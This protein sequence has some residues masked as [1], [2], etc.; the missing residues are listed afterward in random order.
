MDPQ[1]ADS[2]ADGLHVAEQAI[3]KV[4]QPGCDHASSAFVFEPGPPGP[5]SDG[6]PENA[7]R[8][9]V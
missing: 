9:Q 6:L 3:G 7:R 4:I 1:F 2:L 8:T 5:K